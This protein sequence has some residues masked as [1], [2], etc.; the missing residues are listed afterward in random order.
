MSRAQVFIPVFG[1]FKRAL[2]VIERVVAH[3]PPDVI[4]NVVDDGSPNVADFE[5]LLEN[6][7]LLKRIRFQKND[8]N[9]GFVKTVNAGFA[10]SHPDDVIIVNSDCYVSEGWYERIL[11]TS[12][13]SDLVATVT[14]MT[15][16]GSIAQVKL[17]SEILD[18][19][20]LDE[21]DNINRK[22]VGQNK[23]FLTQIPV[24]VGHCMWISRKSLETVGYFD[25]IFSPGYGEEVD[26][27]IRA[28]RKGFHHLLCTD[29]VVYHAGGASFK[30]KRIELQVSH[31][32]IIQ[33]RYPSFHDYVRE[34]VPRSSEIEAAYLN[35]M[36]TKRPLKLLLDCRL[37]NPPLTGTSK[38]SVELAKALIIDS[39]C[40]TYLLVSNASVDAFAE[41]F[42][43]SRVISE[44]TVVNY[45]ENSS[46]F[47]MVFRIGQVGTLETLDGLWQIAFRVGVIQLDFIAADNFLY[48][49]DAERYLQFHDVT[50]VALNMCDAVL[51]LS[52]IVLKEAVRF[53]SGR[54]HQDQDFTSCG[55]NHIPCVDQTF[56]NSGHI[57]ILGASFA[58]KNRDWAIKIA[59]N[60]IKAEHP[61]LKLYLV[62]PTPATGESN[63]VDR[64]L[65]RELGISD[66]T[67]FIEWTTDEELESILESCQLSIS[68][69]ISEG[70]GMVPLE[71]AMRGVT[72]ISYGG[73]AFRDHSGLLPYTLGMRNLAEDTATINHLLNDE[74]AR[75]EQLAK[76]LEI[77][78][79]FKWEN[80]AQTVISCAGETVRK[81]S[82]IYP[83]FRREFFRKETPRRKNG[84]RFILAIRNTKVINLI[85]PPG[86]N[87]T[88]KA[89]KLFMKVIKI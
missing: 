32:R 77:A 84:V 28:I 14:A 61:E 69:S 52:E 24:G 11:Q 43:S 30:E 45:V 83:E 80:V 3:T 59:S 15:N 51:Y 4:I 48:F 20:N 88:L 53:N 62:G 13:T 85:F 34:F 81:P 36:L 64:R 6:N 33:K 18:V 60:L 47:D 73:T 5:N 49:D 25:E 39:S 54:S 86:K 35:V 10:A 21:L 82:F 17:G 23:N 1:E 79:R 72:P 78:T 56:K 68:C 75:R 46:R 41:I 31:E 2:E 38:Y 65:V 44:K 89:A 74:I 58:H 76:A 57:V 9:Q 87:R 19:S 12:T 50:K 67:E 37:A 63:S 55:L 7:F 71:L 66:N 29:T 26:F 16:E 70:F 42:D 8:A 27:C 40:D 22:I